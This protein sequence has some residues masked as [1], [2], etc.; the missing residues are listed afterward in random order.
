[1]AA[2]SGFLQKT[3]NAEG[4]S[5]A[6]HVQRFENGCF[7]S[8]TEGATRLGATVAS[9]ATGPTPVTTTVIP[10]KTESLF[11]KLVSERISTQMRGIAIVSSHVQGELEPG[12]A[13]ALM[14]AITELVENE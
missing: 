2:G 14:S 12:A 13:K 11:L 7:V 3:V 10:A 8:V 4:R 1:M 6:V 5:F 9:L